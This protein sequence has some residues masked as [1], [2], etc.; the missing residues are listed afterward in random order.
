MRQDS[1]DAGKRLLRLLKNLLILYFALTLCNALEPYL[2]PLL[3]FD[4][5]S[6]SINGDLI[7]TGISLVI[8]IYFGYFIL[9]D[10]R[11]F[12]NLASKA[13]SSWLIGEEV[14]RL[15]MIAYDVAVIIALI[16]FRELATPLV[17]CVQ[18]VGEPLATAI[19]ITVLAIVLL[20]VYHLAGQ[21]YYLLK[22]RVQEI[23]KSIANKFSRRSSSSEG[24]ED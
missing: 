18:G 10:V 6:L 5:G 23:V 2:A 4:L 9:L 19:Q 22:D 16:L 14:G 1:K 11:F 21:F 12:L 8:V 15:R 20:I 24:D 3:N 17:R 13:V 7:F